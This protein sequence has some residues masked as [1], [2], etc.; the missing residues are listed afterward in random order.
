MVAEQ[1]LVLYKGKAALVQSLGDKIQIKTD[2]GDSVRV[3]EKDIVLLHPGPLKSLSALPD[4]PAGGDIEGAWELLQGQS[5]PLAELAELIYGS[6]TPQSAWQ[7]QL[8]LA[9]GLHFRGD[10][11]S[12]LPTTKEERDDMRSKR[13]GKAREGAERAAFLERVRTGSLEEGDSARMQDVAAL[14]DGRSDKSRTLKE[15]G[16]P[17]EPARAHKLLLDTKICDIWYNPHPTRFEQSRHSARIELDA[18]VMEGRRDLT[19][20]ES[21]AIDN[22]WSAD[23]DDAI[24]F[25]GT[26][27]YIHVADP[28]STIAIDSP[29]DRE[30]RGR[31]ATLYLP[32]T[33]WRMISESALDAYA[34][35]LS[36]HSPALTFKVSLDENLAVINA[37]VFPSIVAVTRLTY[38]EADARAGDPALK[39]LFELAER[40]EAARMANGAVAI[41]LPEVHISVNPKAQAGE[42]RVLI[43]TIQETRAAAV[44]REFMLLAGRAAAR[45]AIDT[46]VP[47]PFVT[48]EVGDI[49]K[50]LAD[51]LAG[52]WQLRRCMRSRK[53]SARPGR[54]GGLGL[55]E[56]TQVTS[57]LRRYTDLVCHQ[58]LYAALR[59]ETGR[60]MEKILEHIGEADAAMRQAVL[61]E[62][63]SRR[64]WTLVHLMEA[65]EREWEGVVVEKKGSQGVV[66]IPEI[67]LDVPLSLPPQAEL[68]DRIALLCGTVNLPNLEVRFR[69]A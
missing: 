5:V 34:L 4:S 1:S 59:G 48:Q 64:H 62:R 21:F 38:E 16:I 20:L 9:D 58:Q 44:V 13:E 50:D 54:H 30:A 15:L 61:A 2:S 60:N 27:W 65:G 35:G 52:S 19:G 47:F 68:N 3:R 53:L 69:P 17:E 32:E 45:R 7:C 37:E 57:P 6:Y 41:N 49:P 18:P 42:R 46:L 14:S 39:P 26:D 23:P 40:L 66:I 11:L 29:A 33:T 10:P 22:S 63:A 43:E 8:L 67:A 36:K 25:D 12:A 56:Y 55:N 24:A 28:A 31:G 51:G